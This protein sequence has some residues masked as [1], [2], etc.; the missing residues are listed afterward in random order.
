[1]IAR[2]SSVKDCFRPRLQ[3]LISCAAAWFAI[4]LHQ[5]AAQRPSATS[6]A[7]RLSVIVPPRTSVIPPEPIAID[8]DES[9]PDQAFPAQQ[10]YVQTNQSQ[11]IVVAFNTTNAFAHALHPET[12][13]DARLSVAISAS[14]GKGIWT[15]THA[16]D[17]TT[18][19]N[20]D[21]EATVQV[22]SDGP[23]R[24]EVS[25]FLEM[26]DAAFETLPA[27]EYGTSVVCTITSP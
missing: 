22:A 11:G 6:Q 3:V 18:V 15:V 25:L 1:M 27:G 5:A 4:G 20:E 17:S 16:S 23:G 10:W 9:N 7:Q 13:R 21:L 12:K 8:H 2:P 19:A 24:G 26:I 14:H